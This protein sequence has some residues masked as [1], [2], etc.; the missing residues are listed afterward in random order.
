MQFG[1]TVCN[2]YCYLN[3]DNYLNKQI[4]KLLYNNADLKTTLMDMNNIDDVFLPIS[5][6]KVSISDIDKKMWF[7]L[8]RSS[9]EERSEQQVSRFKNYMVGNIT[10]QRPPPMRQNEYQ[11]LWATPIIH[12]FHHQI[13][14]DYFDER[15][16]E[17]HQ[18]TQIVL[19]QLKPHKTLPNLHNY[20][21]DSL[22]KQ[23][24]LKL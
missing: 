23:L 19:F 11:S 12:L 15:L 2:P 4:S 20:V 22:Y 10:C 9:F 21:L 3:N 16:T 1:A 13:V 8:S 5:N 14:I 7:Y 17:P 24:N 6:I 18:A